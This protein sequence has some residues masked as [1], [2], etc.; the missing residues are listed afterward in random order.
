MSMGLPAEP[1]QM[2]V[3]LSSS[4]NRPNPRQAATPFAAGRDWGEVGGD[5]TSEREL[6]L[7]A[8]D[9]GVVRRLHEELAEAQ[10]AAP[11]GG[12]AQRGQPRAGGAAEAT[13]DFSQVGAAG[14]KGRARADQQR[15]P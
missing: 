9:E 7:L 8:E 15:T 4:Q 10:R 3:G 2:N 14:R 1:L 11:P 13:T 5:R 12:G 6:E